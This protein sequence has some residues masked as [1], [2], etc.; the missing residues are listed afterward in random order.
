MIKIKAPA[1]L[2]LTLEVLGRR[3]DGWHEIRSVMQAISLQ[4]TLCFKASDA[5]RITGDLPGW[6]PEDSL[7]SQAV[8]LVRETTGVSRGVSVEVEKYIPLLSGLGGDAS[9]GAATLCGLNELWGLGLSP[10]KLAEL[11]AQLGSDV[12]FFLRGGTALAE[13]RG[14][15]ITPLPPVQGW[16]VVLVLPETPAAPGKTARMYAALKPEHYTDGAMT[17]R[18]VKA[19]REGGEFSPAMLFN[20][21]ENVAFEDN[22]LR[23]YQEHLIKLGAPHVHLAG[24]GPT[25]FTIFEDKSPAEELYQRCCDQ[26]LRAYLAETV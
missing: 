24:S 9:D 1:K 7:V 3:P 22:I 21:F 23:T 19:L 11:S 6:N 20:T 10:D 13:G 5:V 14:E 18:L 4:D 15:I 2:N 25:L 26:G 8:S 16:W 17:E 12:A